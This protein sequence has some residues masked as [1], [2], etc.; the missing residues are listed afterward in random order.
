MAIH[1]PDAGGYGGLANTPLAQLQI[2]DKIIEKVYE[3]DFLLSIT[4]SEIAERI[5]SC[6]QEI[7][8]LLDPDI[9]EWRPHEVG[10]EMSH[11]QVTFTSFKLKICYTSYL[12]FQF[13]DMTIHYTCQ[14][15]LVEDRLLVQGYESY[16][17]LMRAFVFTEMITLVDEDNMGNRAG[18]HK[19]EQLGDRVTPLRV[20]PDNVVAFLSGLVNTLAS[21]HYFIENQMFL[22]VPKSFKT[23]IQLSKLADAS[24][25]GMSQSILID[26]QWPAKL[27]GFDVYETVYLPQF[28]HQGL[29]KLCWYFIAGNQSAYAYAS[30]IIQARVVRSENTFTTKYQMVAAWGG[31]MLYPKKIAVACACLDTLVTFT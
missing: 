18:R 29:Q 3:K 1:L 25:A 6:T 16:V 4:N 27:L 30:D 23:I 11:N 20:T 2:Y 9:G 5:T 22:I 15:D 31:A 28:Y 17:A 10:M 8:I 19:T 12:A 7:Q 14:W 13:D 21:W 26:G 24:Y